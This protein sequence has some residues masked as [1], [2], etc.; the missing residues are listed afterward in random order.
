[1]RRI[2]VPPRH[3]TNYRP[4][5]GH[6][7]DRGRNGC[8]SGTFRN[9]VVFGYQKPYRSSCLSQRDIDGAVQVSLYQ[10]PHGIEYPAAAHS[11]DERA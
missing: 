1:M 11:C 7:F 10:R 3:N 5:P 2:E 6:P 4:V 9:D 8:R